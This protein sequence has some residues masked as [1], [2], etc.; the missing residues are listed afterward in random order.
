MGCYSVILRCTFFRDGLHSV[1]Y[2]TNE[3][4]INMHKESIL[5]TDLD[6]YFTTLYQH[7]ELCSNV[8]VT[9]EDSEIM[10]K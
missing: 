4:S 7:L 6:I 5:P 9:N 10:L 8:E 3:E 1:K 2:R